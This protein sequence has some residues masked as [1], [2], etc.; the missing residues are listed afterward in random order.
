MDINENQSLNIRCLIILMNLFVFILTH[1]QVMHSFFIFQAFII[2]TCNFITAINSSIK[3]L[4]TLSSSTDC[5]WVSPTLCS[6]YLST[7][8]SGRFPL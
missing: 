2:G 4:L 3:Y 6:K 5:R 8:A 1:N 7:T